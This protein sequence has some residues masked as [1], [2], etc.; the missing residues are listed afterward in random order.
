[1]LAR[2]ITERRAHTARRAD[3]ASRGLVIRRDAGNDRRVV[4]VC[5]LI[6]S[7]RRECRSRNI[8]R[9]DDFVE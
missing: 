9:V 8:R 4:F 6:G 5:E 3:D 2:M 7:M 1:M